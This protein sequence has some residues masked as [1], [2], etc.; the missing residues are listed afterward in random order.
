MVSIVI[1]SHSEKLA[2]GVKELALQMS[3]NKVK[4]CTAGGLDD[5][6]SPI[7]T[8]P[9]KIKDAIEKAYSDDGILVL[10]DIGSA[11]MSAEMATEMLED[12]I[13]NKVLLCEAPL[14]EGAIAAAAQSMAGSNLKTV[15]QEARNGLLGK[16]TLLKNEPILEI[17][18]PIIRT[19]FK[20]LKIR[21]PN[22]FGLHARPSVKLVG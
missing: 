11:I 12:S 4:I 8:D 19:N 9:F 5:A 20:E 22:K 14:V 6:S 1:V 2:E 18:K 13:R 3:Q 21:V 17:E 10:M 7:G 15:A 16:I